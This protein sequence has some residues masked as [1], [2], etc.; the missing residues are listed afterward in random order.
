M[1]S[2]DMILNVWF[3]SH[4]MDW[5]IEHC[6][7]NILEPYRISFINQHGFKWLLDVVVQQAITWTN[8]EQLMA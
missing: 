7:L 4:F 8:I 5:Y 1:V 3:S 2:G 6:L